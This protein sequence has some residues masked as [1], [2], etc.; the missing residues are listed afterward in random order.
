MGQRINRNVSEVVIFA[1]TINDKGLKMK[2]IKGTG[3]VL[4]VE[5]KKNI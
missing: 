1:T 4:L 5:D 2:E 3:P